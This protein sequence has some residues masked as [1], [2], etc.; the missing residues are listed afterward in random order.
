[1]GRVVFL[2]SM[3]AV[4]GCGSQSAADHEILGD[5]AYAELDYAGALIEYRLKISQ[6]QEN[7]GLRAKA[8][9][10]ALRAGDLLAAAE[11]FSA[12]VE[13]DDD[14][15]DGAEGLER[16]VASAIAEGNREASNIALTALI[17]VREDRVYQRFASE[18]VAGVT[19]ATPVDEALRLFPAAAAG[20]ADPAARDSL[21]YEY[22][23]VMV[24]SRNCDEAVDVFESLTRRNRNAEIAVR[25]AEDLSRCALEAG[26]RQLLE[27]HPQEA[28]GWFERAIIGGGE[29]EFAVAAYIGLGDALFARGDIRGA[30]EA[31][32]GV[33]DVADPTD[34][35]YRQAIDR[36]N[37]IG[38][39]GTDDEK[40]EF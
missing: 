4:V 2:I 5:R 26:N 33:L 25:A 35:V 30:F 31:F 10:A 37:N 18:M 38:D 34:M 6:D 36:L 17:G 39:A 3:A 9:A 15:F 7:I 11:E 12:L 19:A 32:L 24:R 28:I 1:M 27:G 8:G 23:R 22:G 40:Q 16:V 21:I 14:S 13:L 20:V 29:S